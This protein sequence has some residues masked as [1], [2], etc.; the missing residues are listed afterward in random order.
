MTDVRAGAGH[1][2]NRRR[3]GDRDATSVPAARVD[4]EEVA[5]RRRTVTIVD[6]TPLPTAANA[7]AVLIRT[8][9]SLPQATARH[10]GKRTARPN[11]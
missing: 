6:G 10:F 1:E 11:P 8:S 5:P 3:R 2:M 7:I 4:C 9:E